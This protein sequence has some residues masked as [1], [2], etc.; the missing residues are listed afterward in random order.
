M[1]TD[2]NNIPLSDLVAA[3]ERRRGSNSQERRDAISRISDNVEGIKKL[4][5]EATELAELFELQFS[6]SDHD[7][8]LYINFDRTPGWN[9]S[10]ANC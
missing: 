7:L 10:S 3:L 5:K 6:V 1:N 4:Y 9:S 8:E 2:L